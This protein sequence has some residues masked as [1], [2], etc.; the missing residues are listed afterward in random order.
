MNTDT[1]ARVAFEVFAAIEQRGA[2]RFLTLTHPEFTICWPPSLPWN[3]GIPARSW[4][5]VWESLQP[6]ATERQMD[7]EAI[8]AAGDRVVV[9]WHQ[10]RC[11]LARQGFDGQVLGLYEVREGRLVRAQMFLFD[12]EAVKRFLDE[13]AGQRPVSR[14]SGPARSGR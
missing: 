9:R 1:S 2:A 13:A 4:R 8:A 14:S 11:S 10:G 5:P 7:P 3:G 6:T 12:T